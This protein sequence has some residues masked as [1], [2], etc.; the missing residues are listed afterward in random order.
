MREE[1]IAEGG[2]AALPVEVLARF[3]ERWGC[4][5]LEGYGLSETSPAA[6]FNHMGRPRKVG[7]V[8]EPV[9]VP[10]G[11]LRER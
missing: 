8:G 6:S 1:A 4:T 11:V 7:S 5:V 3:E 10:F 9:S 2:G